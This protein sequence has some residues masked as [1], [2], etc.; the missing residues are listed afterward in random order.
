M[1][2]IQLIDEASIREY[3]K[4]VIV[5]DGMND[6]VKEEIDA[7]VDLI[8]MNAGKTFLAKVEPMGFAIV[9]LPI[10]DKQLLLTQIP[11]HCCSPVK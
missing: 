8:A 9:G 7:M 4:K 6:D 2:K 11:I 3:F 10:D 5:T 1:E